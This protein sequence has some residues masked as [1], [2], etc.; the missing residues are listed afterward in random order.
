MWVLSKIRLSSVLI[1]RENR[2]RIAEHAA[3]A[4]HKYRKCSPKAGL[5]SGFTGGFTL[6]H[7]IFISF[8]AACYS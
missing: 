8:N 5:I 4:Y 2:E 6:D 1:A 3:S 7:E